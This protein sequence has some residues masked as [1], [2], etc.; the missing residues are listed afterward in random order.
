MAHGRPGWKARIGGLV[1]PILLLLVLPALLALPACE[2][3]PVGGSESEAGAPVARVNG[4]LLRQRDF[5]AILPEDYQLVLTLEERKGYLDR[6]IATELLYDEAARSNIGL[7][8]EL[9]ARLEQY[10]KD[11]V[12]DQLVQ[13]VLKERAVVSDEEV[14]AYYNAR[15][16]EYTREYRVSHILVSTPED[17]EEVKELLKT[18]SFAWVE[19][20]HSIDRHTGAG[21]DLGFLSKGNMIPEFEDVVF[22]MKVGEVSDVI[23]S[24]FGYHIIKLTDER[25]SRAKLDFED[26]AEDIS[27][28]LLLQKRAAVYDSL[29]TALREKA[30]IEILDPQLR[31]VEAAPGVGAVDTSES[32]AD[33]VG[34]A[35]TTDVSEEGP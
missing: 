23:E 7:S 14:R 34:M 25:E 18:H 19:R 31:L 9:Q 16:D 20:R 26:V 22:G 28:T 12:A 30:N 29:L 35:D 5:A 11:L 6:W 10:K 1:P 4:R 2:R 27:R 24:E 17:A 15:I 32:P 8:P 33:T 3:R 13:Q 21:G